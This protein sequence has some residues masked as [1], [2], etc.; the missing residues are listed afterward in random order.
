MNEGRP[1]G[2]SASFH[3]SPLRMTWMMPE[4]TRRSSTRG[5]PRGLL[6]NSGLR[7]ANCSSESQKWWLVMA[8]LPTFGGFESHRL[9][10]GNP[11]YGS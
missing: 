1:G 4:M 11:F 10:D 6:G 8:K 2:R 3:L 9:S 5:T 7:G